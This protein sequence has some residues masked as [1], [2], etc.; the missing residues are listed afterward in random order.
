MFTEPAIT[1]PHA[2]ITARQEQVASYVEQLREQVGDQQA[3]ALLI[4]QAG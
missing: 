3:F 1:A 2:F 4:E